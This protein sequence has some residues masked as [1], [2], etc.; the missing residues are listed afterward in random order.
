MELAR[1]IAK[2]KWDS[3]GEG[4]RSGGE[5]TCDVLELEVGRRPAK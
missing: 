1:K 3:V 5:Q 4:N 2:G